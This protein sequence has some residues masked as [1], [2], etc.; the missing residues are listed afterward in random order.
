VQGDVIFVLHFNHLPCGIANAT[1]RMLSGQALCK[2]GSAQMRI[3]IDG[4]KRVK[5]AF[6]PYFDTATAK[7]SSCRKCRRPKRKS[8]RPALDHC[9][10]GSS[11]FSFGIGGRYV[12]NVT[13][14]T[15]K[16]NPFASCATYL[17]VYTSARSIAVLSEHRKVFVSG[18]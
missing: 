11:S 4:V 13:V 3:S 17:Q 5:V 18:R 10:H 9:D 8:N 16:G 14:L 15:F 2:F 1:V 12:L 7:T 6:I